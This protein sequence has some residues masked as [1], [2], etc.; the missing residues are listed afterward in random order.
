MAI[1]TSRTYFIL[2]KVFHSLSMPFVSCSMVLA[3]PEHS[4]LTKSTTTDTCRDPCKPNP[5]HTTNLSEVYH[6]MSWFGITKY[7]AT[8]LNTLDCC[9]N[10]CYM[11]RSV[12]QTIIRHKN[13]Y[14]K[15]IHVL[16]MYFIRHKLTNTYVF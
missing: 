13:T 3:R 4:L 12:S 11:F 15:H 6:I 9:N 5:V 2:C 10:I 7:I 16:D 8:Q 14:L 1:Q